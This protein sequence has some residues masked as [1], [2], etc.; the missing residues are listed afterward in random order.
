M[1]KVQEV[2]GVGL[3]SF[4]GLM[5]TIEKKTRGSCVDEHFIHLISR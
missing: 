2:N 4:P 3:D 5:L 1:F